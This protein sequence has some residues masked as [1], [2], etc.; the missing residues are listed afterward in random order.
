MGQNKIRLL[1]KQS[2]NEEPIN[3]M[4]RNYSFKAT[5]AIIFT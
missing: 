1:A 3:Q 4:D 2:I 5:L